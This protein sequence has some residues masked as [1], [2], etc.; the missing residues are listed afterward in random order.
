MTLD[1]LIKDAEKESRKVGF[2][3]GQALFRLLLQKMVEAGEG[4]K[5][6]QLTD[7]DFLEEMRKKY[8]IQFDD[9]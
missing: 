9:F 4:D 5:L 3:E 6:A 2:E 8:Q 1:E 7:P